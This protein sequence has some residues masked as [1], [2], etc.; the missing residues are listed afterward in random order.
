MQE[1][2]Q[3]FFNRELVPLLKKLMDM[4][5]KYLKKDGNRNEGLSC[6]YSSKKFA[7]VPLFQL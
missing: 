7:Y 3:K 5:G 2:E 1:V 4:D 6:F